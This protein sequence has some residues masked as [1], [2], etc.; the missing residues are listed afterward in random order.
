LSESWLATNRYAPVGSIVKL[1]GVFPSVGA[2]ARSV[3]V[4]FREL[5]ANT[6]I[7]SSPRLEAYRNFPEGCTA[8]SAPVLSPLKSGGRVETGWSTS[9]APLAGSYENSVTVDCNSSITYANL[10]LG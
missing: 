5:I 7:E 10:P 4:P 1:R 2:C 3:R 6:A 8:T 9:K